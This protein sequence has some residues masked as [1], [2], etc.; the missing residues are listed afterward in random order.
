MC[1]EGCAVY[2]NMY[3]RLENF[4]FA[5]PPPVVSFF[6]NRY[7]CF[8]TDRSNATPVFRVLKL[9]LLIAHIISNLNKINAKC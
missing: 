9:T 3:E 4:R 1:F 7:A 8:W 2:W 5:P 6:R